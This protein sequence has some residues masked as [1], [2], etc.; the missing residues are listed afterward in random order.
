MQEFKRE[1]QSLESRVSQLSKAAAYHNDHLRV[2]DSWF[3]QVRAISVLIRIE[4]YFG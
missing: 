1:K 3:K 4:C 2:I